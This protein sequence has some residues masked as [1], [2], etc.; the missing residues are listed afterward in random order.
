M[1]RPVEAAAQHVP[2]P[3]RA[4]GD[5]VTSEGVG[6]CKPAPPR[7]ESA[8]LAGSDADPRS[9]HYREGFGF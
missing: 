8:T 9:R 3:A 4:V 2:I 7:P 5:H 6:L 1:G